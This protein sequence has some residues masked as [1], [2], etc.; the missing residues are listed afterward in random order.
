MEVGTEVRLK[1]MSAR[2]LFS[3]KDQILLLSVIDLHE[4]NKKVTYLG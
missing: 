2:L 1:A 3:V 4:R